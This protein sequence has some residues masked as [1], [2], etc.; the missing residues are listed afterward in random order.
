VA[1]AKVIILHGPYVSD[2]RIP[3]WISQM[4]PCQDANMSGFFQ[5]DTFSAAPGHV[6][7]GGA[8]YQYRGSDFADPNSPSSSSA[9][10]LENI[11]ASISPPAKWLVFQQPI[12]VHS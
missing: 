2:S 6:I 4:L 11:T 8:N 12:R 10:R 3:S 7:D 5:A 1:Q 9:C